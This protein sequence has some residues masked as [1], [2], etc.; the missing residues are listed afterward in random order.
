MFLDEITNLPQAMQVKLLRVF[1]EKKLHRVGGRKDIN[2]DVRIIVATN[3]GLLEA[4]RQGVFREDL[5]HRLNEFETSLP[6]LRCRKDDI[7]LLVK[8]FLNISNKELGKNVKK[9]S[10]RAIR[11]LMDYNWPGN[12]RELKNIVKRAVLLSE[13]QVIKPEHL[14]FS[15]GD[16]SGEDRGWINLGDDAT[17]KD[18]MQKAE[19]ALIKAALKKTGGSK[20][21]A[22]K[23][24]QIN[25]KALYRKIKSLNL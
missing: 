20:I 11:M 2:V 18:K 24:L 9:F 5:F 22:A 25:R 3:I 13:S 19:R 8:Y 21:K 12:V 14:S 17:L 10:T 15:E 7:P 23:L 16:I 4:V 1:Q 6:P